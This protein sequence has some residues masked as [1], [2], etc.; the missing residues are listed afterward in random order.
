MRSAQSVKPVWR[1][2]ELL[3][4]VAA[5]PAQADVSIS[6]ISHCSG[7]VQAGD[8]FLALSGART[9]GL[10]YLQEIIERGAVAVLWEPCQA[11][12]E[13]D[14]SC[15]I[16][17]LKI[18]NLSRHIGAIAAR[19]HGHPA[20]EITVVGVTGTDGKTSVSQFIA[21]S[22][23]SAVH[24][25]GVIGTL[26]YGPYGKLS[27][28]S[29]TTP[30]ALRLQAELR[31]LRDQGAKWVVMEVSSHALDQRR[32]AGTEID[33]A[34][35]TNLSRDHFDYHGNLESYALAK[36]RLFEM[37]GLRH[38]ILNL[39]DVFGSELAQ[40]LSE[41]IPVLGYTLDGKTGPSGARVVATRIDSRPDGLFLEIETPWG[42]G[43]LNC[44]LLGRFNAENILAALSV[45]L[46]LGL[47]FEEVLRR[48]RDLHAVPGRMEAFGGD[49]QPLVVV[50]YAHTPAALEHVL[51]AL[52]AHCQGRLWCVFGCGGE[53][54]VGK[55]PKMAQIAERLADKVLVTDD[56][57]RQESPTAIVRDIVAGFANLECARIIHDRDQAI[58]TAIRQARP[59]DVVL[60]A[61]KGHELTQT[62]GDRRFPFNDRERVLAHLN[63]VS[64]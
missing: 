52:R 59:T 18:P 6:G 17:C 7:Q 36:R 38:A 45:L 28:A 56:N 25:C 16:P 33:L 49:R 15:P 23:N 37:P 24:P 54:D 41:K 51:L 10:V 12:D 42:R 32:V 44:H 30:D 4:T 64:A 2:S 29:H 58:A 31:A 35:L 61:G 47:P 26:G 50:D 40:A 43:E 34:V 55:R 9:H 11:V 8:L 46:V 22:L 60:V 39:D 27:P 62:V 57:P 3:A 21:Q 53:R 5:V 14:S 13:V 48:M 19:F 63:G 1:V 20:R